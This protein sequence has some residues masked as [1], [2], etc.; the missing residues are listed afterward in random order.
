LQKSIENIH[1]LDIEPPEP[2]ENPKLSLNIINTNFD[3]DDWEKHMEAILL[4]RSIIT[5][6]PSVKLNE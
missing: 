5:Y 1:L 3:S 4:L 6:N 2:L